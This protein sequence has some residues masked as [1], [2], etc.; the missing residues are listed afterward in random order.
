MGMHRSSAALAGAIIGAGII[1]LA[2]AA[3]LADTSPNSSVDT[4]DSLLKLR[5]PVIG[6][7]DDDPGQSL[8]DF[9]STLRGKL[10]YAITV[11]T[12]PFRRYFVLHSV[13]LTSQTQ[14]EAIVTYPVEE[15]VPSVKEIFS[16]QFSPD[17]RYILFKY[18]ATG[19]RY[20]TYDLYLWD[21]QKRHLQR[22]TKQS[23]SSPFVLWSPDGTFIAYIRGSDA[24]GSP[25]ADHTLQLYTYNLHTGKEHLIV[26]NDGVRNSVAWTPQNTL[27]YSTLP[28]QEQ[29]NGQEE[30]NAKTNRTPIRP[31]VHESSAAGGEVHLLVKDAYRPVV[32]PDGQWIVFFGSEDPNQA[33]PLYRGWWSNP[34]ETSLSVIKRDGSGRKALNRESYTYPVILWMSDSKRFLT[35]KTRPQKSGAEAQIREW[36]I[37]TGR[38]KDVAVLHAKDSVELSRGDALPYFVPLGISKND[39][40]LLVAVQEIG[41]SNRGALVVQPSIQVIDLNRGT[42]STVYKWGQ[43]TIPDWHDESTS[44]IM[45]PVAKTK[46]P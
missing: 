37:V 8:V 45:A 13:S 31:G 14:G 3:V 30:T 42:A 24:D 1:F 25:L 20:S 34:H 38:Q 9:P 18:G 29:K 6:R 41:R 40:F 27:L 44:A 10:V 12:L 4:S 26:R 22:V 43:G 23:L 2:L 11:N 17:G 36:N 33:Q 21:L 5:P 35:I 32:S 39:S 46:T 15:T 16:P 28:A 19:D 7:V